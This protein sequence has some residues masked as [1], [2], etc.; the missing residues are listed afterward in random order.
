MKQYTFEVI[1]DEG[2]DEFWE[3]LR[4]KTGCDDVK[5]G[6]EQALDSFGWS[7]SIQLKKFEDIK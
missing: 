5:E 7:Y 6:L 3:S 1:V 2:Y 4:G